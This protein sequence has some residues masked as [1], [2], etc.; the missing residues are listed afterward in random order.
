MCGIAGVV[1]PSVEAAPDLELATR[2]TRALAHRGPDDEGVVGARGVAIGNRRLA[3]IDPEG[4]RQPMAD[5][6]LV[7]TMNGAVLN[8]VEIR[9]DLEARGATFRTR[10]D[11]EVLLHLYREEGDDLVRRLR[12]M[13]AFAIHDRR[14]DRV[15][16]ARDRFGVKPLYISSRARERALFASEIKALL[17]GLPPVAPDREGILEYLAFGYR[18]GAGT[19]F[20]GV[21]RLPPGH[22]AILEPGR[23]PRIERWCDPDEADVPDGDA[24]EA[25]AQALRD[26]VRIALRADVPLGVTL[27]GGV[28]SSAVA[29]LAGE[30]GASGAPA[31][32]GVFPDHPGFDESG[33]AREVARH[34]GLESV[35]V[36]P[37]PED[38]ARDMEAI[39]R[40]MDEPAGGP[41]VVPQFVVARAAGERV[42]VLLGGQGG[43]ELFGG[44][45]RQLIDRWL[46]VAAA[47]DEVGR[48][49]LRPGLDQMIGYEGLLDRASEGGI[50]A[51]PVVRYHRLVDRRE[52]VRDLL[53]DD[54]R[55]D[56]ARWP[57]RE[58][59]AAAFPET[60]DGDPLTR[61]MR[62]ER[63]ALLPALL[64]VE[65][66]ASM[67]H[68]LESRVP[69]LDPPVARLALGAPAETRLAGGRLKALLRDAT[70]CWLPPRVRDRRDKMGFPVPLAAWSAGP[71][72]DWLHDTL[73]SPRARQR[74]L[75]LPTALERR[76]DGETPFGRAVWAA[77][78]LELWHRVF[79]DDPPDARAE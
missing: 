74:G 33:W 47:G 51:D 64:H 50:P 19:L 7:V 78:N 41:G 10:S 21:E 61:T 62:Y 55:R 67:A 75:F 46:G 73:L 58:A 65:D 59:F 53:S 18:H 69:L 77:L 38:L 8:H 3:I 79:V 37:R 63:T 2:M 72:R 6:D 5:G 34:A 27:S 52:G 42:R 76:I 36:E 31:Y 12:G 43:D 11:T 29:A 48:E 23:T 45:V 25:V 56:L 17:P 24:I 57:A 4:G 60:P 22:R 40:A 14:R 30:L 44:Y 32:T 16:L 1:G 54:L 39:V 35:L 9:A 26:S 15:L 20:E 70:A 71:L 66:R 49:A 13:F 28:D 68:G